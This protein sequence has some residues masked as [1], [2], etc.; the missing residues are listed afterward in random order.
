MSRVTVD[1]FI[2]PSNKLQANVTDP[3]RT[4]NLYLENTPPGIARVQR[5]MVGTPGLAP[6][7]IL[8]DAPIRGMFQQD[9]RAFAVGGAQYCEVFNP[10][11][12]TSYGTVATDDYLASI[13]S[14]GTA[15]DQNL[16]VSGGSG[17]VHTLSTNAFAQIS[18]G[19]FPSPARMCDF[20]DG[21]GIV[22]K[23]DSR[24]FQWS[25]LED[26]TSWDALDV[27]E[28]SEGSDNIIALIRNHREIWLLGS[29]TSEVWYDQGDPLTPFAPIQG[30]FIEHGCAAPFSVVRINNTLIWLSQNE[31]G[32]GEV[33]VA[34][35][36][37]PSQISTYA[38][39][40]IIRRAGVA[41]DGDLSLA[42]AWAYQENGHIF[43][44]LVIPSAES[45]VCL[46]LT[47]PGTWHERARWTGTEYIAHV[48]QTHM[49]AFGQHLVGDRF[50]GAIYRQSLDLFS[51][52]II[53]P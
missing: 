33:V 4:I 2:G 34:N 24:T 18:D 21:Y 28:R 9:M 23:A 32:Q 37:N 1:G 35:G 27:A 45:T 14:N 26:M 46:D 41:A 53:T 43:Y 42:K 48:V 52:E 5:W 31:L 44:C 47:M 51:E 6:W 13:C 7:V 36:Y 11:S 10:P 16:I 19:D 29:K 3:E 12:S 22:S 38:I 17:Y 40:A 39:A 50:S 8:G 49:I 15:G 20:M 30:T 25:A